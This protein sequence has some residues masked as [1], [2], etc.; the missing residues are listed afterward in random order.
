MNVKQHL[1]RKSKMQTNTLKLREKF[2]SEVPEDALWH[3][4]R[5]VGFITIPRTMPIIISIID[6]LTKN[7]SAGN[8]YFCLWCRSFDEQVINIPN[9]SE[10]ALESGFSGERAVYTW[11]QRMKTL[12]EWG[13]IDVRAGS[14]EFQVVLILN[15]HKVI[16][17]IKRETPN[18]IPENL[19][20]Q[21]YNRALDVGA[22]DMTEDSEASGA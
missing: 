5:E 10:L 13:F 4:K 6:S 16:N 21:L 2:W 20:T 18:D 8:T 12:K 14:H 9:P 1:A 22:R 19:Y 15:P 3:R 17:R 11:R 7:A